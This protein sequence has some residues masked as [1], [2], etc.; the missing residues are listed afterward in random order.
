MPRLIKLTLFCIF[1]G[2]VQDCVAQSDSISQPDSNFSYYL[3]NRTIYRVNN[4][5][6]INTTVLTA[7]Y[8][9]LNYQRKLSRHLSLEFG[10]SLRLFKGFELLPNTNSERNKFVKGHDY[11]AAIKYNFV[12][13]AITNGFFYGLGYRKRNTTQV[14][15]LTTVQ[16]YFGSI[17]TQSL[18]HGGRFTTEAGLSLGYSNQI[19]YEWIKNGTQQLD[20]VEYKIPYWV[21]FFKLK[22][23]FYTR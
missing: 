1:L 17:G 20:P 5:I 22:W 14:D 2:C 15:Y 21:L 18:A 13:S 16:T 11:T 6:S 23:Y 3:N 10:G 8:L 7:G 9:N 4:A 19:A 12:R